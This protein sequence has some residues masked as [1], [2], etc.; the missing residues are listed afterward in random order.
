MA[1]GYLAWDLL[2]LEHRE[3]RL[4]RLIERHNWRD[5]HDPFDLHDDEFINLYRL[6]PD[7]VMELTDVL[8]P[9]LEHQRLNSLS[10]ERQ[11]YSDIT[12]YI[13]LIYSVSKMPAV[14]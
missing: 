11:V 7:I 3:R 5:L 8:R 4:E 10:P 14:C 1:E 6:T 13:Y 12:L 2:H 9:Y